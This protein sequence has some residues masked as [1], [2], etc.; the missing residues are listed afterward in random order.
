MSFIVDVTRSK[1]L[2]TSLQP[3]EKLKKTHVL[4]DKE[5]LVYR[6]MYSLTSVAMSA[7]THTNMLK[8][9]LTELVE[10]YPYLRKTKGQVIYAKT[11]THNTLFDQDWMGPLLAECGLD[12]WTAFSLSMNHCASGLSALHLINTLHSHGDERPFIVLCGEKSFPPFNK[13][14]V[15]VLGEMAT[16]CLIDPYEGSWRITTSKTQHLSEFYQAPESMSVQNKR[17]MM[18][19]FYPALI[20]F[21]TEQGTDSSDI[22]LSYNLNLPL[23]YRLTKDLGWQEKLYKE[24]VSVYGHTFCSDV[25]LNLIS[26]SEN[27]NFNKATLFAAG[28]GV[29]FSAVNI[30]RNDIH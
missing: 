2:S 6:R 25:F 21:L 26:A 12:D 14:S 9:T 23:L 17:K 22:I 1:K 8:E 13:M 10:R 3:L 7:H 11:Q 29:T 18:G 20:D 5:E 4:S 28:M 24:N 15:G 19:E 27:H 30:E 16:A